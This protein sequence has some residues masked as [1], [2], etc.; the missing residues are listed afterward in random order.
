MVY[1]RSA[2]GRTAVAGFPAVKIKKPHPG[3]AV[4]KHDIP[5]Q[6]GQNGAM[7]A[8]I[9]F[10]HLT[11]QPLDAVLPPLV[12]KSLGRGWR[13][14]IQSGNPERVPALDALLWTYDDASFLPHATAAEASPDEPVVIASDAA[15]P[16]GA[17]IRFLVE[18]A[19]LPDDIA[20]YERIV[21]MFDGHDDDAVAEARDHWKTVKG[22]GLAGTYWQQDDDGRWNKKA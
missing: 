8:E 18:R 12:E 11:R 9:L 4:V 13:V 20:T 17:A 3:Y 7:P 19:P 2:K 22:M 16:N 1:A 10:Y 5:A 21:L 14:V 15:N 6:S